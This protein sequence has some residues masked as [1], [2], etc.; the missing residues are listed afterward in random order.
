LPHKTGNM[1]RPKK[2]LG[3]HFLKDE[4]IARRIVEQLQF[5][6]VSNQ[7]NH[8]VEIGPGT[9]ALTKFLLKNGSIRLS[10]IEIDHESVLFI[11]NQFPHA[12]ENIIEADI[13]KVNLDHLF[14]PKVSI[15]GNLPYNI[16]SQIFFRVLE[17][18]LHVDQLVCMLQKEVAERI[19]SK[20][21]N[22]KYGIL[23]V[24]IQAFYDCENLFDVEPTAFY[25][26]P[27]V[28]SAVIRLKRNSNLKLDCDE[29]YFQFIVKQAFQKRRKTLRNALKHLNLP[30]SVIELDLMSLRPEQ[31]CVS[32]Y[33]FLT[34]RIKSHE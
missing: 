28:T 23:S 31:L 9:G 20:H 2:K 22:K 3:Q 7:I 16:A 27:K 4:D 30:P 10:M 11:K 13:L 19:C 18:R 26:I 32:D 5:S 1:I 24:L 17:H 34:Q 12:K 33:I 6:A 21:G 14:S 15:I 25:P 8:V 29:N